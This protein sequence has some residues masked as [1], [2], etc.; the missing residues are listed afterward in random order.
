MAKKTVKKYLVEAPNKNYVGVGA[1]G[2]QFAYGKAIVHEGW[3]LDWYREH[4]YKVTEYKETAA[5]NLVE[6][7][8]TAE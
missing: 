6:P 1:A 7:N 8:E 2:V 4:G 3:V 5:N